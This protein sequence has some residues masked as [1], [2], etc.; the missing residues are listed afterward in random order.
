[1]LCGKCRTPLLCKRCNEPEYSQRIDV[2][3]D[4]TP[5]ELEFMIPDNCQCERFRPEDCE[6]CSKIKEYVGL[7]A[8]WYIKSTFEAIII[9]IMCICF[10]GFAVGMIF[11]FI[12]IPTVWGKP[13]DYQVFPWVNY[14]LG[15][16]IPVGLVSM[17]FM[18][19][20]DGSWR[21]SYEDHSWIRNIKE[22]KS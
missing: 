14:V 15:F 20:W 2:E 9:F 22:E 18:A 6:I 10:I 5:E 1:M 3:R 7:D 21:D 4:F 11:V 19:S 12:G 16:S 8:M 17:L 13:L